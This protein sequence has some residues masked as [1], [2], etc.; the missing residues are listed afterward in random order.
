MFRSQKEQFPSFVYIPILLSII[1][2]KQIRRL[3]SL[4]EINHRYIN[5][6]E[7]SVSDLADY[8]I[9]N[10][11]VLD[12]ISEAIYRNKLYVSTKKRNN[13]PSKENFSN[14]TAN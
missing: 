9:T 2:R 10:S 1:K 8:K 7:V 14:Y 12:I 3:D 6:S 13:N 11:T 5:G 4:A